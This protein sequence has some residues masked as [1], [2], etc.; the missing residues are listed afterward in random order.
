MPG[1]VLGCGES[2]TPR[3]SD[4]GEQVTQETGT[5][6]DGSGGRWEAGKN[7]QK[8]LPSRRP[9]GEQRHSRWTGGYTHTRPKEEQGQRH[10]LR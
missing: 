10:R 5:W 9:G 1:A 7:S 8:S 6:R 3:L 2:K 4:R